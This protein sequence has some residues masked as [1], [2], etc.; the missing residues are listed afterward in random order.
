MPSKLTFLKRKKISHIRSSIASPQE[1]A[2]RLT[3][4]GL[5]ACTESK[6]GSLARNVQDLRNFQRLLSVEFQVAFGDGDS[7]GCHQAIETSILVSHACSR[8]PFFISHLVNIALHGIAIDN[9]KLAIEYDVLTENELESLLQLIGAEEIPLDR[10]PWLVQGER[11]AIKSLERASLRL[12]SGRGRCGPL[13]NDPL[14]R[15][16]D[17]ERTNGP[18]WATSRR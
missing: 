2:G 6:E 17:L 4:N 7:L 8:D 9:A 10:L 5:P 15:F 16:H 3:P 11:A 1:I 18:R 12:S 13:G 14:G